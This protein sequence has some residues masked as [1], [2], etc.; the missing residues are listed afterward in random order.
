MPE[1]FHDTLKLYQLLQ[2]DFHDSIEIFIGSVY[3]S[4]TMKTKATTEKPETH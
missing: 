2:L 3:I 1:D 4:R